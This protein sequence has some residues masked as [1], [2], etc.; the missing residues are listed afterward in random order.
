[1]NK[2]DLLRAEAKK[3]Y[4]QEAK[5][6]ARNKRMPFSEFWKKFKTM[7]KDAPPTVDNQE[8]FNL[9]DFIND[10]VETEE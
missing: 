10:T 9:D 6:V 2:K 1:M 7:K 3:I 8:D 4:K 5:K